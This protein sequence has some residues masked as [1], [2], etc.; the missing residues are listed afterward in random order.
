MTLAEQYGP[1]ALDA[2]TTIMDW[3]LRLIL[4]IMAM[5]GLLGMMLWTGF[6]TLAASTNN[7]KK[8]L[9]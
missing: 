5:V 1:E 4:L 3:T 8:R 7:K 2:A 9:F 6:A